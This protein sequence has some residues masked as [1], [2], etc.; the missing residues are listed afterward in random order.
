M[1]NLIRIHKYFKYEIPK[2]RKKGD[3]KKSKIYVHVPDVASYIFESTL[4][5]KSTQSKTKL[6][7]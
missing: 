3:V 4:L 6:G 7:A 5:K 2:N 1:M